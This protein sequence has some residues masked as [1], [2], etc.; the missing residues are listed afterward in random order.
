MGIV[1]KFSFKGFGVLLEL[2]IEDGS[3]R[4]ILEIGRL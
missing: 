3:T 1:A 4:F 2:K